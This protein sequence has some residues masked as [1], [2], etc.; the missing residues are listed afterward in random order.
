[1]R[2]LKWGALLAVILGASA[3]AA[4]QLP[5]LPAPSVEAVGTVRLAIKVGDQMTQVDVSIE[6]PADEEAARSFASGNL[7][8][9]ACERLRSVRIQDAPICSWL[10]LAS[11]SPPPP[12]PPP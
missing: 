9:Y 12:R 7:S 5:P 3:S 10:P 8:S 1:M 2:L 4:R 11:Q 6:M